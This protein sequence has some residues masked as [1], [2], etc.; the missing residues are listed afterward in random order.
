LQKSSVTKS[1][2]SEACIDSLAEI[3]KVPRNTIDPN[4][5]FKRLGLDSGMSLFLVLSL[6]E[7]LGVTLVP[8]TVYDYPT[9]TELSAH[10]AE[11]YSGQ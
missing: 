9:V 5:K 6:E 1:V 11:R 7:R 3:L 8:E 2:I 4:A 10:L